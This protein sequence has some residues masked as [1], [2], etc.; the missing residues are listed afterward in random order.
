MVAAASGVFVLSMSLFYPTRLLQPT[1]AI[2]PFAAPFSDMEVEALSV[3]LPPPPSPPVRAHSAPAPAPA[4][5]VSH[6]HSHFSWDSAD[7][8][9]LGPSRITITRLYQRATQAPYHRLESQI[10]TPASLVPPSPGPQKKKRCTILDAGPDP[11]RSD[12]F[13]DDSDVQDDAPPLSLQDLRSSSAPPEDTNTR[14]SAPAPRMTDDTAILHAFL[15]RAAATKRPIPASKRESLENRRDSD[16]VRQ[17]LASTDKPEPLAELDPNSPPSPL[18]SQSSVQ[19]TEV[20]VE[21][22]LATTEAQPVAPT[23]SKAPRR[24]TRTRAPAAIQTKPAKIAIRSA[25]DHVALKRSEAVEAM[26]ER[27]KRHLKTRKRAS[28]V[29]VVEARWV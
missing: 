6:S 7:A 4:R 25:A 13:L 27:A 29:T 28:C 21:K 16:V 9:H 3:P 12:D 22:P 8:A 11:F 18:K 5:D 2:L 1:P 19:E 20:E 17:A 26:A 14:D 15:N 10:K 23:R 24:T